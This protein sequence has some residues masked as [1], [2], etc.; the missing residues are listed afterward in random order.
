MTINHLHTPSTVATELRRHEAPTLSDIH[1]ILHHPRSLARPVATWRPPSK[2]LPDGLTITLTRHRVGERVKARVLG[3]G[4]EREPAY[5]LTVRIT[6]PR[7][8][9]DPVRAEGWVR[10]LVENSLVDAVHEVPSGRAA[11]FVWLSDAAYR[12]VHSPAAL[13]AGFSAAA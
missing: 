9:V 11:T 10:A 4:E 8:A 12:P 5:L 3:F 6:D 2:Q 1:S 13:F 7:G